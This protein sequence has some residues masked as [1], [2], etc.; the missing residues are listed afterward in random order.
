MTFIQ[1]HIIFT[2]NDVDL[3]KSP[4]KN[5]EEETYVLGAFN[6]GM[7]VL[8]NGNL[9]LVVRVAEALKEPIKNDQVRQIRWSK[10][11]FV[12]DEFNKNAV[13]LS[14]PRKFILKN[15]PYFEVHALSSFSWI[16]PVEISPDGSKVV[17]VH[18][19]KIISSSH[20][21]EE[22]GIEDAR[23]SFIDGTYYMTV[24]CISAER[25]ATALYIS[26]DGLHYSSKGIVL[27]HGNKDM[28]LFEG[29]IEGKFYALTRPLGN[30]FF[31]YP[32]NSKYVPGPSIN[33]ASSYDALHWKPT[34]YPSIRGMKNSTINE[35]IGGGT[36]PILTSKGWLILYHGVEGTNNVGIYRTF[37]ALLDSNNPH[38]II[39]GNYKEALLEANNELT[40][41]LTNQVYLENIVFSTGIVQKED[42]FIVASGELDLCCRITHISKKQFN[43]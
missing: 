42:C 2:P 26:T 27:D 11:G 8:P 38:Q 41:S 43:L 23:L 29:K 30:L 16:L 10:D 37:W 22:Y 4:L 31:P 17:H 39:D 36:Q 35:R 28:L 5:L 20:S 12:L 7:S 32:K 33:I 25:H 1:D 18:Y 19:D 34:S 40:K 3:S 24:C 13:N 9:I 21:Y 15:Y 14:D 6:P